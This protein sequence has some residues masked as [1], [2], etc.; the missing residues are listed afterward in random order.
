MSKD[1]GLGKCASNG[2]RKW[3]V[4]QLNRVSVCQRHLDETLK[5]IRGK[6]D[7]LIDKGRSF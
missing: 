5:L 7:E 2:C 1:C 6:L 3:A 4:C